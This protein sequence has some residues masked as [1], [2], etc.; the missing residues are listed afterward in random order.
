M[1]PYRT[2]FGGLNRDGIRYL[3]AGGFAVNFHQVQRATVDLD[4]II[5]IETENILKFVSLMLGLGFTPRV[6][7]DPHG[8]ADESTR[9]KW[10]EEK[11]MLVFTFIHTKNP[12]EIIDVFS[13]EP[14]PFDSLW[15]DRMDVS[16]F[17][18]KI[19]VVGKDHLI[20]LKQQ[21]NREKDI[22]DIEQLKKSKT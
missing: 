1:V 18:L 12:L 3:V 7:V 4:L 13:Q 6:P 20:Q 14:I 21:A 16:A 19:P 15:K 8:F 22:F 11:G 5:Q 17:G 10:I 2:V 9:R